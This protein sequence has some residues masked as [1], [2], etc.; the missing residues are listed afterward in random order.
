MPS[1]ERFPR[2]LPPLP[3]PAAQP[4][5]LG[6]AGVGLI[7]A[8][9]GLRAAQLGWEVT[10]W[11]TSTENLRLF[12]DRCALGNEARSLE[13]L[14]A[15]VDTL[16]LAA[17]LEAT[18]AHLAQLS[19]HPPD[20]T[21]VV[22]VASLKSVVSR[23]GAT[24]ETFVATHP[25][26]GSER[27]GP[28]AADRNL[29][30]GRVWTYDT[31]ATFAAR[32][33]AALF[34]EAMGAL[35]LEISSE[36]HDR[37]VALTSHL[38]QVVSVALGTLLAGQLADKRFAQLSGTGMSSMLR[39]AGSSW[40][41]WQ[42]ILSTNGGAIAQEVRQLGNILSHIADALEDGQSDALARDFETAAGAAARLA[43]NDAGSNER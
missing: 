23:A 13:E 29:F 31:G 42:S 43:A 35:P 21:L 12:R 27:S 40:P 7:G 28:T 26:A 2:R 15:L 25:I 20:A 38:P 34:I 5:R 6:I 3:N 4:M 14:G 9:I 33:A 22:D 17:P 8:S 30:D 39:L 10:A 41:M 37:I 16:V 32:R 11:D 36:E 1:V 18:L 24:L 19:A